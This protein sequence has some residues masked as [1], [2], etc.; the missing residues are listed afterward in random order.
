MATTR[1]NLFIPEVLA[2]AVAGALAGMEA[3]LG[4]GAVIVNNSL[5]E[6]NR[7]G[8]TVNVPYFG[9]LGEFQDVAEGAA[10]TVA[11]ITSS[12]EQALVQR[13]G[14]AFEITN[15]AQQAAGPTDPYAEAARQM[16][17]GIRR[18]VDQVSL[19]AAAGTSLSLVDNATALGYD[20]FVDT[21]ALFGDEEENVVA[22]GV[23]SVIL[24]SLRKI[25]DAQ[26]R[27][28]FIDAKDGKPPQ[29]LGK[30]VV[31]SDQHTVN[32]DGGG[33]GIDTYNTLAL[34][35]G[36]LVFW[37][38]GVPSV[39]TDKDILVD[40]RVAAVNLY[41]ASHLYTRMPGRTKPGVAK[42]TTRA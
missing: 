12:A 36:S 28:I 23:H 41:Y 29:I 19:A 40:S 7:G 6:S 14:K 16:R 10:L 26:G 37:Y 17:D 15:W 39:D 38:N 18:K 35:R 1:A 30:P 34:R 24:A 33:V 32:V 22:W 8:D 13:T 9:H 3:I 27:P 4:T 5:P 31:V 42:L 11:N 2:D 20:H 25:K 21:L